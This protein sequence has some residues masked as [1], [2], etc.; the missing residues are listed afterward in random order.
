MAFILRRQDSFFLSIHASKK[1]SRQNRF[2]IALMT[3]C[4]MILL[5]AWRHWLEV[6]GVEWTESERSVIAE[7]KPSTNRTRIKV[8]NSL[9]SRVKKQTNSSLSDNYVEIDSARPS[10]E[11][12]LRNES[13]KQKQ[14]RISDWVTFVVFRSLFHDGSSAFAVSLFKHRF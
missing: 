5:R 4:A 7:K 12:C 3:F 8:N 2:I 11:K 9:I 13:Q 10:I 1:K 14:A 6:N